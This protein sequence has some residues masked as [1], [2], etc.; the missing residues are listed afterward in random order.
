MARTR[1]A[2]R[3][4]PQGAAARRA[5]RRH[6]AGGNLQDREDHQC[7]AR[8]AHASSWSSTT[9]PSCARLPSSITVMHLGQVLAEGNITEIE[10]NPKVREAY[11]GSQGDQ[12]MLKLVPRST[13]TTA[14]AM[15]CTASSRRADRRDHRDPRPQRHRQDHAAQDHHGTDRSHRPARSASTATTSAAEPTFR[16]ARAG[17]AYVPQGREIIPD[18]TIR[19]NILMGAFARP[20]GHRAIPSL[21]PELFP[22]S[23]RTI[24]IAAAACCRAA[25]SSNSPSRARSPPSRRCCCSTSRPRASSPPSSRKSRQVIMRL[26]RS[27]R[28]TVILVEQNVE[29]ARRAGAAAS[30]SWR[31]A[32]SSRRRHRRI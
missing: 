22:V 13:A 18:F 12:L 21:V 20:D 11:L 4:K 26:N 8:Q 19:E 2:D 30:P 16:R 17:F 10:R 32:A 23:D 15:C 14:A 3:A 29:F 9:W 28:L 31:R 5:D 6:D 27:R 1:N 7:A 25:S 24:S